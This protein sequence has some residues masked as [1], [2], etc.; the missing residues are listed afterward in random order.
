MSKFTPIIA[1][2]VTHTNLVTITD[3]YKKRNNLEYDEKT[4]IAA[5]KES[6]E[7]YY[8]A[9]TVPE[10]VLAACEFLFT[11]TGTYVKLNRSLFKVL[12]ER[13]GFVEGA[14]EVLQVALIDCFTR[15]LVYG[16]PE[17]KMFS[18]FTDCLTLVT[19]KQNLN[20]KVLFKKITK[21]VK[22]S[23]VTFEQTQQ[24]LKA[25]ATPQ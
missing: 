21:V 8:T 25:C 2:Y 1:Q 18:T 24:D 23:K 20:S 10:Y 14:E 7:N 12:P 15:M 16:I 11:A 4:E 3:F 5:W 13:L 17:A 22:D 6:V 9:K 19:D